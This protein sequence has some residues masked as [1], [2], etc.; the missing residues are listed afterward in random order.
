[1]AK[2][3]SPTGGIR[4]LR[5]AAGATRQAVGKRGPMTELPGGPVTYDGSHGTR[6]TQPHL[7]SSRRS[8]SFVPP[9]NRW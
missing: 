2:N 5:P 6:P 4:I 3:L 9:P 7:R 1:M 8:R